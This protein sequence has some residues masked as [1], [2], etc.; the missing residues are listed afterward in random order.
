MP[1][2][3]AFLLGAATS[4]IALSIAWGAAAQAADAPASLFDRPSPLPFQ[5][6]QFDRI[7]DADFKPA[8]EE[9]MRR[10]LA[11]NQKIADNPAPPTFQN[12]IVAME[13]AGQ[14][15]GRADIVFEDLAQANTD[16]ALQ[17]VQTDEEPRL[18]AHHDAIYLNPKLFAR[19]KAIYD[20]RN[21]LGLDP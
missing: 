10:D 9:G 6:P 8:L 14:M 19:V 5:A 13:R 20:R 21:A 12:T 7:K 3:P 4:V 17:Q 18:A 1:L 16:D 2:K 15:L 11:E